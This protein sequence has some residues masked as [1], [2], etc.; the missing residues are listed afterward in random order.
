MRQIKK[1]TAQIKDE[2]EGAED[3]IKDAIKAKS[4]D[5]NLADEYYSLAKEEMGHVDRLHALVVK[6][7][8]KAR[9]THGDPPVWMQEEYDERHAE[10]IHKMAEIQIY[11][12]EYSEK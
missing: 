8:Q 12:N 10:A 11:M 1:L 4:T 6:E 2:L 9:A 7:I 5:R 3:Y